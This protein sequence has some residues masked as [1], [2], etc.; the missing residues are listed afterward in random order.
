MLNASF[1]I[2]DEGE[3]GACEQRP[4]EGAGQTEKRVWRWRDPNNNIDHTN[5]M[6]HTR[7]NAV[8]P[9]ELK[10]D[11]LQFPTPNVAAAPLDSSQSVT[12]DSPSRPPQPPQSRAPMRI[13][14]VDDAKSI[15]KLLDRALSAQGHTCHT[16]CDGQECLDLVA[17]ESLSSLASVC[18][19]DLILMDSEMPVMS[20]P[21]ATKIIRSMGFER[22]VI[23]GVTGNVLPEDVDMFLDHGVDAVL[24]KPI[25]LETLWREYDRIVM[26]RSLL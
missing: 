25:N 7:T 13:L 12:E 9:E 20:G 5:K 19:Y 11:S 1:C 24:G 17:K 16:A 22:L 18:F 6:R 8:N 14:I 23:L 26:H 2:K 10:K 3:N 21:D 15:R 4:G